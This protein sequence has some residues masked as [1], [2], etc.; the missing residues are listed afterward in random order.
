[1][2]ALKVVPS[3]VAVLVP[4]TSADVGIRDEEL[5]LYAKTVTTPDLDATTLW[6]LA[7]I[8]DPEAIFIGIKK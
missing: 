1:M 4:I 7:D 3:L 5:N 8:L 6:I 2:L